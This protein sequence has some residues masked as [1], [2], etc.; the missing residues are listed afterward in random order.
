VR[1]GISLENA[2]LEKFDRLIK[3][4]GCAKRGKAIRNSSFII[5]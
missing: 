2:L 3:K 4:K 1:F 5:L